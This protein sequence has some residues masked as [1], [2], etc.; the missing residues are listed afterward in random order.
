MNKN[1]NELRTKLIYYLSIYVKK[2]NI[3]MKVV[4]ISIINKLKRKKPISL[5]QFL[6]V[7]KFLEREKEFKHYSQQQLIT[8]FTP[9]I[10]TKIKDISYEQPE[11]NSLE[12]FFQTS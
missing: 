8:L 11:T 1:K 2:P 4:I 7:I 3:K 6:S 9:I 12:K 10:Y 5:N